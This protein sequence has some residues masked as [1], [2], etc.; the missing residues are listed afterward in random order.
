MSDNHEQYMNRCCSNAEMFRIIGV[1]VCW[2]K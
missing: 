1:S 2:K